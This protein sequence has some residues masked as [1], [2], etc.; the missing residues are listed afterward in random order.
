M[1]TRVLEM[2][3]L[4]VSAVPPISNSMWRIVACRARWS[5]CGLLSFNDERFIQAECRD[6][7]AMNPVRLLRQ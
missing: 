4:M 7:F 1:A 6:Q 5:I 3:P 2:N